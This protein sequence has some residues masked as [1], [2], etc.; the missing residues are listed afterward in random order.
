MLPHTQLELRPT[1][2]TSGRKPKQSRKSGHPAK[3]RSQVHPSTIWFNASALE[4]VLRFFEGS[5]FFLSREKKIIRK[6]AASLMANIF[7]H[8]NMSE[9]PEKSSFSL[10]RFHLER[11]QSREAQAYESS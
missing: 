11:D 9:Q 4:I 5:M 7:R 2:S 10:C 1:A 6:V 8:A 3:L